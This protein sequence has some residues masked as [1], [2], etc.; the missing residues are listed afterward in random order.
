MVD[1]NF[2]NV[3]VQIGDETKI[4]K[5]E[6]GCSFENN[7]AIYRM[8]NDGLLSVFDKNTKVWSGREK[9]T[10]TNYQYSLFQAVANNTKEKGENGVVLSKADID[11]ALNLFKNNKLVND[12]SEFLKGGYKIQEAKSY[13][14]H[15]GFGAF[16]TNGNKLTSANLVFKYGEAKDATQLSQDITTTSAKKPQKSE[17]ASKVETKEVEKKQETKQATGI[18]KKSNLKHYYDRSKTTPLPKYVTIKLDSVI[19]KMNISKQDFD[20]KVKTTAK[21]TNYSEYFIKYIIAMENYEPSVRNT[22]D[23][24]YTGGFGHSKLRDKSLKEGDKVTPDKAFKWL[25]QDIK[26]FE[27]KV[28]ELKID[29]N[30]DD[31]IGKYYD[32]LPLSLREAILDV[33]FNR[34]HRKLQDAKEY[35]HLRANI[36]N[37]PEY[38]PACAVRLRQDFSKYTYNEK[39]KNKFTTGL[40]ERNCYRFFL[41]IRDFDD[42]YRT[43]AKRRFENADNYYSETVKLKRAKGYKTDAEELVKT[44]ESM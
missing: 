28:K 41:A 32:E 35:K 31:T 11:F 29:K 10:M 24:T 2:I 33:A 7:G 27:K 39:L 44:W 20:K 6:K 8:N 13:S 30:S 17:S 5:M 26:F 16:V 9:I 34:D 21:N 22:N 1:N 36:K 18:T 25:E 19:R 42:E 38:L 12:L 37:G 23:G 14:K 4:I 15:N 3:S 43:I 40:M